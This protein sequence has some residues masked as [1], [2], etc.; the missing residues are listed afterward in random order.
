MT[1]W[2]GWRVPNDANN[3]RVVIDE[4]SFDFHELELR[5]LD[6]F[7]DQFSDALYDLRHDSMEAWKPPL[8]AETSCLDENDL[9]TFVAATVDRDVMLRFFS[10]VDKCPEWD[11]DY[12]RCE[13]IELAGETSRSAWSASFAVTA[14]KSGHGVACLTFPGCQHRGFVSA[15]SSLG[16]CQIFF[17]LPQ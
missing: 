6:L 5:Q 4:T 15:N 8:F 9:Y 3:V 11:G 12:P 2:E 16:Q 13:E 17:S 10:L 14:I 7:L 1:T